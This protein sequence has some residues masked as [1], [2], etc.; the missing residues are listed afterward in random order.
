MIT[1][2]NVSKE[3]CIMLDH[4]YSIDSIEAYKEWL[5]SLST[6]EYEQAINLEELIMRATLDE[7]IGEDTTDNRKAIL[8]LL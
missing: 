3:D 2:K 1:I 7:L 5:A 4:M 6:E 8:D